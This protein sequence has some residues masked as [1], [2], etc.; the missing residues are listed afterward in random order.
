M[1]TEKPRLSLPVRRGLDIGEK[2]VGSND[3]ELGKDGA[4][5]DV[6]H[7]LKAQLPRLIGKHFI[8]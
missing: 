4:S 6:K 7:V 1:E 8:I 2:D 5:G 3:N